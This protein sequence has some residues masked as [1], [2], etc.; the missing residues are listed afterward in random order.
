MARR[1]IASRAAR[2]EILRLL[3]EALHRY[4]RRVG[5][6]LALLVVAKLLTVAVPWVLKRIVDHLSAPAVAVLPVFLL[7]GYAVLRFSGGLVT[8]LRDLVFARVA[9]TTVAHFNAR[10]AAHLHQLGA[11]FHAGRQ[12]GALA[13]DVER[14]TVG[15]NFLLGTA[16]FTV[17]PTLVEIVSV[18]LILALGY[19]VGFTWI[20]GATFVIYATITSLLT[21][22]RTRYQRQLNELDS[23]AGGRLIDGLLNHDTVKYFNN[24]ALE[25]RRLRETLNEWT[26]VGE[27]NQRALSTLHICQSAVIAL[28]VGAVML[29]A[30]QDVLGGQLTVGDLVLVNAYIIQICLPLN[31]L[32]MVFRQT[33]EATVNAERACELLTLPTESSEVSSPAGGGPS[34]AR[35]LRDPRG[36]LRFEQVD[37]SYEPGR[38]ILHGVSFAVPAGSTVA[39]V[40]GSGSGKST[41]ARLLFRF[42]DPDSG[43]ITLGGQDLREV[44]HA[45]LR[46]A[47][48]IVPQETILFNETIAY[49]IGYGRPGASMAEIIEAA[50]GARVHDF[51]KSLPA[52]YET[53]VGERGVKL[54]GGERQRI[55]IARALLKNPS[56]LVFDEATSALDTR[57]ERAIQAELERVARGRT[58]LVIAHRLS[59]VVG[60]DTILVLEQGRVVERGTHDELLAAGGIYNQMW[61]LQRQEAALI[62]AE[63]RLPPQ[64]IHL[65]ALV[66]NLLDIVRGPMEEKGIR[67]YTELGGDGSRV[68]GDPSLVH[69]VLWE[70]L[71]NAVAVTPPDGRIEIRLQPADGK[72]RIAITDGRL[73]PADAAAQ[74]PD[75]RRHPLAPDHAP[76]DPGRLAAQVRQ[77]GGAFGVQ[78]PAGG[79]GATYWLELPQRTAP[80]TAAI[81]STPMLAGPRLLQGLHIALTARNAAEREDLKD[82][83]SAAGARVDVYGSGHAL[84][85]W[86]RTHVPAEWPSVLVA[87][88]VLEDMDGYALIGALRVIETERG[89]PLSGRLPAIAVSSPAAREGRLRALLAGYQ[90]HVPRG[91]VGD[92]LVHQ[93]QVLAATAH[94]LQPVRANAE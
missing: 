64:P 69:H 19:N 36:P 68:T 81:P 82:R 2:R 37:F 70:L 76:P 75:E 32:G 28:G 3:W 30:G 12:T 66:A 59:T 79:Y 1:S 73:A 85:D 54:S 34:A 38:Q 50:A 83:L 60:A 35:V 92:D 49:N 31:T 14:G 71:T 40:G 41:L 20:I 9:L 23:R 74:S 84:L 86:F 11:R 51:I 24:E 29:L 47:L 15:L 53:V 5:A 61:N 58:T 80:D 21:A 44:E 26:L 13:R 43:H 72:V 10:L 65:G 62:T 52:Q 4:H 8:E 45:S 33:R 63:S 18:V 48:G 90:A 27:E 46:A 16:L 6:A 89:I 93:A 17:L 55:A 91:A 87:D 67:L 78:R 77:A 56:V 39:V 57:T 42:Y 88:V 7:L 22:R 25:D 94:R